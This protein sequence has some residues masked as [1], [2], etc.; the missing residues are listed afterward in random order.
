MKANSKSIREKGRDRET[1]PLGDLVGYHFRSMKDE[2][3][4][5]RRAARSRYWEKQ[6][7]D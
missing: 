7:G 2:A 4:R 1:A 3:A 5:I 6:V